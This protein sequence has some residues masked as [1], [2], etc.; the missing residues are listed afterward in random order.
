MI[1]KTLS[2]LLFLSSPLGIDWEKQYTTIPT[3]S[4]YNYYYGDLYFSPVVYL[5]REDILGLET[6]V[7]LHFA[8]KRI[9][10][11]TLVLGPAGMDEF[12]CK[13]KYKEVVR[14]LN[15]K[16]G[17]YIYTSQSKETDIEDLIFSA[18]CYPILMGVEVVKT[19]WKTSKYL[20]ESHLL[21]DSN[22]LYIEIM[23]TDRNRIKR[24]TKEQ[25]SK[26]I[27]KLSKEL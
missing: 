3:I 12:G 9:A 20:I 18:E 24:Y 16:Y 8:N 22:G 25:E 6:E 1:I 19:H 5:G 26:I 27:K 13:R 2:L 10:K 11:A 17:H 14:Y 23:Y 21:G 7:H 15:K 4:D